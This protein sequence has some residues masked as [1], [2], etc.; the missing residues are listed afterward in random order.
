MYRHVFFLR[1]AGNLNALNMR[2]E[3]VGV[4]SSDRIRVKV[5]YSGLNLADIFACLGL[6]SATPAGEFIPGLEFSGIVE[7]VGTPTSEFR[8]GDLVW[9]FSRFGAYAS[10]IDADPRYLQKIPDGWSLAEAAAFPV[11]ALT[12][13]YG[14]IELGALKAGQHVLVQSAAGGVGLHALQILQWKKAHPIAVIGR[15][16][17]ASLLKQEFG[18]SEKEIVLRPSGWRAG[19]EFARR[20]DLVSQ[21]FSGAFDLVL[22]AVAGPY[23]R[24]AFERLAPGGR[25]LLFGAS[26]FMPAGLRPNWLRLACQYMMRYRPDPLSMISDNRAIFGFNLIWLYD[27][28][29]AMKSMLDSMMQLPWRRPVIDSI[30]PAARALDALKHLKSGRTTGKVLL[31]WE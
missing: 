10:S 18:L 15:P 17:K 4:L 7:Q 8:P 25:Y 28:I 24:P 14:L 23:L 26:D 19:A 11:Q 30:F 16:E 9:G 13:W 6:Y 22:D 29:D 1:G 5:R 31:E 27:R 20:L 12:A 2:R 21:S 3:Q